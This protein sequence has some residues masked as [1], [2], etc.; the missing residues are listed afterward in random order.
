MIYDKKKIADRIRAERKNAGYTQQ[1]L[2]NYLHYAKATVNA[3]ERPNGNNRI[4]DNEQLTKLCELFDCTIPYLL[5]EIDTRT[6]ERSDINAVTGLTKQ[7]I[8]KLSEYKQLKDSNA[9]DPIEYLN[10]NPGYTL[11]VAELEKLYST[12]TDYYIHVKKQIADII[13]YLLTE[14]VAPGSD[15]TKLEKL[16]F[17]I[18]EQSN[19]II[20]LYNHENRDIIISAYKHAESVTDKTAY[21]YTEV[22]KWN[23]YDIIKS[24]RKKNAADT[25]I[26]IQRTFELAYSVFNN[27]HYDL[28][29]F[30]TTRYLLDIIN[31]YYSKPNKYRTQLQKIYARSHSSDN[32]D[33]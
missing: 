19:N 24:E 23:Y 12:S 32:N 22:L 15:I 28:T 11:S 16:L 6:Q 5:C 31:D 14:K 9:T 21:D 7:A 26:N 33:E 13:S 10:S 18:D 4:P 17:Q 1:S 8:D 27:D 20:K 29:Q 3:W 25:C 30:K 2:A